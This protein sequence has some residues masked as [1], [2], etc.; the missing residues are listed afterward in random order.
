MKAIKSLFT[1]L[2]V[3]S[4]ISLNAVAG[5]IKLEYNLKAGDQFKLELEQKQT[6]SQEIMGQAQD[7][8]SVTIYQYDFKVIQ[9]DKQGLASLE[10]MLTRL[11][12]KADNP[13]IS[14][15]FDS[16][17]DQEIPEFIRPL[18][19][20]LNEVYTFNLDRMGNVSGLKVPDG[21]EDRINEGVMSMMQEPE[22]QMLAGMIGAFGS[23]EQMDGVLGG[24]FMKMPEGKIATN[25]SWQEEGAYNQ[26]IPFKTAS[27]YKMVNSSK[28]GNEISLAMQITQADPN[29][30][31][32]MEGMSM[33]YE[34]SGDKSGKLFLS[35]NGLVQSSEMATVIHGVISLESPQ[36]PTPLSIPVTAQSVERIR[37]L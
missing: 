35:P 30:T 15:E 22:V 21:L 24:L 8:S 10:V 16:A 28:K 14:M 23:A 27:T 37:K 34:L 1:T 19:M 29:M 6:T 26:M 33:A 12:M 20:V 3:V 18:L 36:I 17:G 2:L 32:E 31:I 11:A 25:G 7:I 4:A 5:N 13:M 9:V